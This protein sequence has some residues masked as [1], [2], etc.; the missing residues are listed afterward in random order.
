M[1]PVGR[2]DGLAPP[3]PQ[4]ESLPGPQESAPSLH[5]PSLGRMWARMVSEAGELGSRRGHASR[6]SFPGCHSPLWAPHQPLTPCLVLM[7]LVAPRAFP[8][9]PGGKAPNGVKKGPFFGAHH[10]SSVYVHLKNGEVCHWG[11]QISP[12]FSPR[13]FGVMLWKA[14]SLRLQK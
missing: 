1:G 9:W 4:A 6:R 7:V 13:V 14:F 10:F 11:Q 5:C 3:C 8:V 12:S 2:R